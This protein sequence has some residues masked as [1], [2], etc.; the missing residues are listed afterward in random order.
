MVLLKNDM[1]LLNNDM[2]LLKNAMVLL[3]NAMVSLNNAMVLLNSAMVVLKWLFSSLA[4][5]Y[6]L[7][8]LPFL[9]L[10]TLFWISIALLVALFHIFLIR[11]VINE[12]FKQDG[13]SHVPARRPTR[14]T[15]WNFQL[16]FLLVFFT[17]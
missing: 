11:I 2:V 14:Y 1:V 12:Y 9:G 16:D 10:P 5:V 7:S 15:A 8:S 17:S 13:N 4:I 6:W 3:K